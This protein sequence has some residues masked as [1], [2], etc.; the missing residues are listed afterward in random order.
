MK[1]IKIKFNLYNKEKEFDFNKIDDSIKEMQKKIN[2]H[3]L[4]LRN[5]EQDLNQAFMKM[6]SIR[7]KIDADKFNKDDIFYDIKSAEMKIAESNIKI[8]QIK[9]VIKE[10][11]GNDIK[12]KKIK[13][14]SISE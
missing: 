1:I 7:I 3:K 13:D 10:K 8:S 2:L 12:L 6:E 14:Y 4:E 11:F 9:E 5:K